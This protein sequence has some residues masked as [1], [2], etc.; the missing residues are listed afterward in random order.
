MPIFNF[1]LFLRCIKYSVF[2][3]VSYEW[4][5]FLSLP[6]YQS[7]KMLNT[8]TWEKTTC[9][10][11]FDGIG[12]I[13]CPLPP[14]CSPGA[15][16]ISSVRHNVQM[17]TKS[18]FEVRMSLMIR[19]LQKNDVG[20][21]RCAAKNSL[22]EVESSIRLYGEYTA[23]FRPL[24]NEVSRGAHKKYLIRLLDGTQSKRA[25]ENCVI[26]AAFRFNARVHLQIIAILSSLPS[27]AL[28]FRSFCV[29]VAPGIKISYRN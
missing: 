17:A 19:N 1:N 13:K 3:P 16:I 8:Q 22:G 6:R 28:Y 11:L 12:I 10:F 23:S 4:F 29:V 24:S 5:F 21:Y 26:R 7:I 20:T 2:L 9:D 14:L 27:P 25:G 15:M 18:P